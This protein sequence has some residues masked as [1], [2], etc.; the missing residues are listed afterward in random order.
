MWGY[1]KGTPA[2]SF[3]VAPLARTFDDTLPKE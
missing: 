3:I 2:T 1:H